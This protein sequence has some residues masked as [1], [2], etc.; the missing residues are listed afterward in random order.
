LELIDIKALK[1]FPTFKKWAVKVIYMLKQELLKCKLYKIN[2]R[3]YDIHELSK[4]YYGIMIL[5]HTEKVSSSQILSK[6][7]GKYV[8]TDK[9]FD[10][11]LDNFKMLKLDPPKVFKSKI[12]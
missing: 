1:K 3:S 10:D 5:N 4:N 12:S 2:D 11:L 7:P 9:C 8:V 6:A